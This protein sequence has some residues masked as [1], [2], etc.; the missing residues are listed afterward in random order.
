MNNKV[1]LSTEEKGLNN[2]SRKRFTILIMI[3]MTLVSGGLIFAGMLALRNNNIAGYAVILGGLIVE[4]DT[5]I[6]L[7]RGRKTTWA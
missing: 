3:M 2:M 1:D 4:V 5:V 6:R 7:I